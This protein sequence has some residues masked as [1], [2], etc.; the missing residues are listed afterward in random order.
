MG[1][2]VSVCI[3]VYN[4]QKYLEFCINSILSQT[5]SNL[6]I[7]F[8]DDRSTDDSIS[9]IKKKQKLDNR[10]KL[11]ENDVNLGLVKNW[12]KCIEQAKGKW[13]KFLFQDDVMQPACVE[14]MLSACYLNKVQICICSREFIIED[15]AN[16]FLKLFFTNQVFKLEDKYPVS[17]RF[18]PLEIVESAK[19]KIFTNFIG[20][21]I[22]LLFAKDCIKEV[23]NY[24]SDLV[25]L[26]DYEFA[27]R[28]CLNMDSFFLS[29]KL[30]KFRIHSTS[31]SNNQNCTANKATL[32]FFEPLIMYHEYIFNPYFKPL[33]RKYGTIKLFINA[34]KFYSDNRTNSLV[35]EA[36]E[37]HA[38]SKYK[39]IRLIK[40]AQF[41]I[42][43]NRVLTRFSPMR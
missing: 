36:L 16:S 25:Q 7:L 5:Y 6:E 43:L 3:P 41:L 29:E 42:K 26:V 19:D 40:K 14:R 10:I 11:I 20:E 13:I 32:Q 37:K 21:P 31:A 33:R 12:Q 1:D 22:V 35:Y 27:L 18:T 2:L 8:I 28:A 9:I 30:V 17:K 15:S 4:G 24:N 38:I 23:G 34:A 39:G